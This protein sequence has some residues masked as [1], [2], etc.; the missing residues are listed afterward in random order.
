M[1]PLDVALAV[2]IGTLLPTVSLWRTSGLLIALHG[3][4]RV[5]TASPIGGFFT[6]LKPTAPRNRTAL[7]AFAVVA[8]VNPLI[9]ALFSDGLASALLWV[10]TFVTLGLSVLAIGVDL[11]L[12][13]KR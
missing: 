4:E 13:D 9:F 8:P 12:R 7:Y 5:A 3:R 6:V 2:A 11:S 10:A 1:S